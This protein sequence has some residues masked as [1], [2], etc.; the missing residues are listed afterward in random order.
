MVSLGFKR[1]VI[2][3]LAAVCVLALAACGG[4]G[5]SGGGSD[6][7][8]SA[9][10]SDAS[11]AGAAEAATPG[12]RVVGAG[13]NEGA[14]V[15][16]QDGAW[17]YDF[18]TLTRA[19]LATGYPLA[20]AVVDA[21]GAPLASWTAAIDTGSPA[22]SDTGSF[23]FNGDT[24]YTGADGVATHVFTIVYTDGAQDGANSLVLQIAGTDEA[25]NEVSGIFVATLEVE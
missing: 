24:E 10:A 4:S 2:V 6:A 14:S 1:F 16:E 3:V 17:Y 19:D 5:S 7:G 13:D 25:G 20:F 15:S 21:A 18:G 11:D 8:A 23:V 9:G 22:Q 12:I